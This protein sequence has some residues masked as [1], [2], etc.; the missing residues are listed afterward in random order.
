MVMR[1]KLNAFGGGL[2]LE[3][4]LVG[5]VLVVVGTVVTYGVSKFSTS[6][7]P[8]VCKDWNKNYMM[9]L[10]LFATGVLTHLTFEVLG[11]NKL[12]CRHGFAC[13]K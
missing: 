13:K 5:V 10:S 7:L 3:A 6:D 4:V 12:Y 1:L 2:I 8:P 9:E 11:L